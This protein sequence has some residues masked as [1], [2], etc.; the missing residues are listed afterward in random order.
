MNMIGDSAHPKTLAIQFA[1]RTR[2]IRVKRCKN[3]IMDHWSTMFRAED[4]M[5][6]VETQ[7]LRHAGDY[8]SGLQPS[9]VL[10]DTYL[11]LR[12]RLVCR[13]TSGP[14][15]MGRPISQSRGNTPAKTKTLGICFLKPNQY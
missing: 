10:A 11:G 9:T 14:Q 3:F 1:R 15:L 7:C 5:H 8:M 2:E 4:D 12:P 13:R 6:Q